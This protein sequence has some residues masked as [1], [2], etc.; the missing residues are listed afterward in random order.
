M[1]RTRAFRRHQ[2]EVRKARVR[3]LFRRWDWLDN[4]PTPFQIGFAANTPHPCSC[5]GCGN[6]RKWFNELSI[7]E[8]RAALG[9]DELGD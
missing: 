7:Q 5:Y 6:P 9:D 8:R 3:R 2:Y 1:A 4:E